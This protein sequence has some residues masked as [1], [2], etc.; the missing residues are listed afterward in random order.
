MD[1]SSPPVFQ[2]EYCGVT[3]PR[4][5]LR[6]KDGR[7]N[8]YNMKQRF[9]SKEHGY[10]GRKW[11]PINETG[12]IHS[13]GYR[14]LHKRGGKKVYQHRELMEKHLGRPLRNL[15]NVHHKDGDRLNNALSNLELWTK[16]QPPGQRVTDKVQFA[17]EILTLYPEFCRTAGYEL[18]PL[19]G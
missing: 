7:F 12:H 17:I 6:Y 15:E 11:R 3:T 4:R 9:C 8:G 18:R 13:S 16:M 2:C 5:A 10:K 1:H 14:R 19:H